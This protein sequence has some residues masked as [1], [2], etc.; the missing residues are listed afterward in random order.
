M[1]QANGNQSSLSRF[2]KKDVE[3]RMCSQLSNIQKW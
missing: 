2:S 3:L 1:K